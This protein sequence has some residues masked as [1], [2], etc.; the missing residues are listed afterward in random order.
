MINEFMSKYL[1]VRDHSTNI[2]AVAFRLNPRTLADNKILGRSGYGVLP[3]EQQQYIMLAQ[4]CGGNGKIT[5][6]PYDWHTRPM[7]IAHKFII[8]NWDFIESGD[9]IDARFILG[10]TDEPCKSDTFLGL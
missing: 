2:S 10:E 8:N 9:V 5:C 6:D 3:H 1:E 7:N 4:L